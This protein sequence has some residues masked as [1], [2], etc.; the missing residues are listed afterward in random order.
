MSVAVGRSGARVTVGAEVFVGPGVAV[1]DGLSVG[2]FVAGLVPV[3]V[4]RIGVG[5]SVAVGAT[6][7]ARVNKMT[8]M[9]ERMGLP[10]FQ[11]GRARGRREGCVEARLYCTA[12]VIWFPY[13]LEGL[14]R[15]SFFS[16]L[17]RRSTGFLWTP[18]G[19]TIYRYAM[20]GFRSRGRDRLQDGP[21]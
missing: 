3:N 16:V 2:V 15:V 12:R 8:K 11:R 14:D 21:S 18:S 10:R 5:V 7:P 19:T 13:C 17:N 20:R 4:G 1:A 6:H 9:R